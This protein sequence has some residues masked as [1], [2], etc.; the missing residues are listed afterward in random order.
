VHHAPSVI[1]IDE[2]DVIATKRGES[3]SHAD[4]RLVTQ[5]LSLMD[6]LNKVDGVVILATTNRIETLDVALRRPGRFDYELYIGPP[7]TAGR[8]QVRKVHTRAMPLD[9]GARASLA[10]PRPTR[11]VSS[12]PT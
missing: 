1:F 5:L 11:R 12:A 6:G 4:T 10:Q 3:C 7:G 8:A 2:L 9:V